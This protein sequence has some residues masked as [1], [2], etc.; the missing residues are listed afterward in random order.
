MEVSGGHRLLGKSMYRLARQL[1][2][3]TALQGSK[4]RFG[5]MTEA[6]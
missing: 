5:M 3:V 6:P 4:R 2:I 1:P